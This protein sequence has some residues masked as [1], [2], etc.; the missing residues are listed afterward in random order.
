M[1]SSSDVFLYLY[2][3]LG[4]WAGI[5]EG[6]FRINSVLHELKIWALGRQLKCSLVHQ[7]SIVWMVNE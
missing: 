1:E 4:D 3:T 2:L 5:I 6:T 7:R